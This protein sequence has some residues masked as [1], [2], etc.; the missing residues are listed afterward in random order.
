LSSS[1]RCTIHSH[2]L[3]CSM[4]DVRLSFTCRWSV[5][6][7]SLIVYF[8]RLLKC[9]T[10]LQHFQTNQ[11]KLHGFTRWKEKTRVMLTP[12]FIDKQNDS[13]SMR[14]ITD[15]T[16]LA[17]NMISYGASLRNHMHF[18]CSWM[19]DANLI[20]CIRPFRSIIGVLQPKVLL[21]S[22]IYISSLK[23][24]VKI[25]NANTHKKESQ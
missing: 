13:V 19:S 21:P 5:I 7:S 11:W 12:T 15:L 16:V 22:T 8:N 20:Y 2:P 17:K 25:L 4:K 18:I 3:H 23:D 6:C 1:F 10:V 14:V 9:V 24:K